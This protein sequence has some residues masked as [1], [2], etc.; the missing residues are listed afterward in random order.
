MLDR[1]FWWALKHVM[2]LADRIDNAIAEVW[3]DDS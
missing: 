1:F 3:E 2:R